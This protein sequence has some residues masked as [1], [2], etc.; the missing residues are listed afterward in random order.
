MSQY[1]LSCNKPKTKLLS[2][3]YIAKNKK[4]ESYDFNAIVYTIRKST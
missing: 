4:E 1:V 2:Q 3:Q